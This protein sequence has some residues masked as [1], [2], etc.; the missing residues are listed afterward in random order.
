MTWHIR[1]PSFVRGSS[2]IGVDD[3]LADYFSQVVNK[4]YLERYTIERKLGS[5]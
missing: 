4:E 2:G 5:R 1:L 3:M